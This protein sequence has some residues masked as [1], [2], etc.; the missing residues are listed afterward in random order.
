[1][2]V[3]RATGRRVTAIAAVLGVL[4]PLA[5]V[6]AGASLPTVTGVST[7]A[8]ADRT[9]VS[10]TFD[11]A[12]AS[13]YLA[14]DLL[15]ARGLRA[16]F[17]VPSQL[18]GSSPYYMSWDQLDGLVR[19]GNEIGGH[20]LDHV[21]LSTLSDA[22]AR[23]QVCEDRDALLE[24]FP[25]VVSFAYPY[26]SSRPALRRIAQSC[27]YAN[28]RGAGNI[29]SE[30]VCP[31][32]D[33]AES[34]PPLDPFAL[35]TP[36][37]VEK[38]TTFAQMRQHVIQ[39]QQNGGGWVILVFHGLCSQPCSA[40]NDAPVD[41]FARLLDWLADPELQDVAVRTVGDVLGGRRAVPVGRAT[42]PCPDTS[43]G[44]GAAG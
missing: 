14:R 35:R 13:Q 4:L 22:E 33:F 11:D 28:A 39:A 10:I 3:R 30:R 26:A 42:S 21:D 16:T 34:I 44:A 40:T 41:A 43:P 15:A 8:T 27:G 19:D 32:C 37:P 36:D 24:R 12:Q 25:E 9:V 38:G 1:M 6:P 17:Y 7:A 23:R 31:Q 18:I 20:T 5:A 29:R 2:A